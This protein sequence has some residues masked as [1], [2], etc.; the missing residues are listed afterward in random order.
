M[1]LD[2]GAGMGGWGGGGSN[3]APGSDAPA[4]APPPGNCP[5]LQISPQ[6]RWL[7]SN[8]DLR[9]LRFKTLGRDMVLLIPH[10]E[11]MS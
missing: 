10:F 6:G 5:H 2:L 11:E 3:A 9:I 7:P 8:T 4:S 1:C